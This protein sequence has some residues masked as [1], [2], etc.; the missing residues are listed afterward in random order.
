MSE[1]TATTH[2]SNLADADGQIK[3]EEWGEAGEAIQDSVHER[4][5]GRYAASV[6]YLW[7]PHHMGDDLVTFSGGKAIRGRNVPGLLIGR[8]NWW[9]M[10][11]ST[12][13]ARG[14][15]GPKSKVGKEEIEG[16][17]K[18]LELFRGRS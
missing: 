4:R 14:H 17:V 16:M 8:A 6:L 2:F 11:W 9:R 1:W 15:I 3:V 13:V 7:G 10:L 5:G 12:T 18:A